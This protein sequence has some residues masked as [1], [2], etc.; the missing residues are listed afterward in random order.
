MF[1]NYLKIA[2]RNLI[3]NKVYSLINISGLAVGM[4]CVLLI[5]LYVQNELS[6]DRFHPNADR[7]Y[8]VTASTSGD[9]IPTWIGTPALLGTTLYERFPEI[10]DFTRI[11]PFGFKRKTLMAYDEKSFYEEGFVLAD[12]GLFKMFDFKLL[13]GDAETALANRTSL[14]ITKSKAEKFFGD[15]DPIGK[16]LNYDGKTDFVVSG[17]MEDV[18]PNSHVSFDFVAPFKYLNE[19]HQRDVM[20]HWGMHNY[21]TYVL[22]SENTDVAALESK[23]AGY[24]T[25]I[26]GRPYTK[27]Y[28]QPITE[29][30][31]RS[32]IARD[33]HHRGDMTGIYLYTAIAVLILLIACIN[34]MNL[35]TANSEIRVK[36]VGMRKV[37]GAQKKQLIAQ[38]LGEALALALL[39]LP[40]ALLL[41]EFALPLFNRITEKA[42]DV[43]YSTGFTLIAGL[44]LLTLVVGLF[45][46]SYP[47][48][49]LSA[50][51]PVKMMH[52]KFNLG[53]G[54]FK[55][56]NVLVVFQFAITVMFI[57]GALI[58]DSQMRFVRNKKLGYDRENIVNVPIYSTPARENYRTYR[59]EILGHPQIVDATA[60]S[61]TPSVERWREGLYFEGRK[62]TD[63][64]S[65]YRMS[66]D[67]NMLDLFG[68]ELLEGR[69]FD[70]EIATDLGKAFIL[71]ESAVRE[72][73]WQP[74]E[75]IGKIFGNR[76]GRVIG[77]AKDFNFRSLRRDMKP[78]AINVFPRMFQYVSV[79]IRPGDIPATI[80]FLKEKWRQTNPGIPFEYY[81]FDEDFDKLYKTDLKL[82]TLFGYFA[83]LAI[84]IACLGLFGLSLFTVQRRTK[85]IGI[86]KVLGA[87]MPGIIKLLVS[88]VVKLVALATVVA[89]PVAYLTMNAWLQGFVYRTGISLW[90]FLLAGMAALLIALLTVSYQAVRAAVGN[91]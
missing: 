33:A 7:I 64:H 3:K 49:F 22:L 71:N 6:Y 57:A 12:P 36:E 11:D 13:Q 32:K 82:Q 24:L 46:G 21:Y 75:A 80:D 25:E 88:G 63:E 91:P 28:L 9:E 55:F 48:F 61:F 26:S 15:E 78:L 85:E 35:Y 83:Y 62:E 53:V 59:N 84:F 17:V 10:E 38:F 72:I 37:L 20:R 8:R 52:G 42:L 44:T 58:V 41:V 65:F 69:T 68:M 14:V 2:F 90:V 31:L 56:R 1:K 51:Q 66:G 45:S 89:W 50:F 73:G 34:F 74:K 79:K 87:S 16:T 4:A 81:F 27:I 40:L 67:F 19:I 39:A 77:V 23:S 5:G 30:H 29:I 86:R 43:E 47:A 18:P 76:D 54:S 60:T 70:R